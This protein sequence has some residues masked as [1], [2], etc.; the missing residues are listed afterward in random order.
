MHKYRNR[1]AI[2]LQFLCTTLIVTLVAVVPTSQ[3]V[4][5]AWY[6]CPQ[7]NVLVSLKDSFTLFNMQIWSEPPSP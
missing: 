1:N 4:R 7:C 3:D 6:I 2:D 5:C